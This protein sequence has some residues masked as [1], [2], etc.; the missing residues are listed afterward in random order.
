MEKLKFAYI[1]R[2]RVGKR[3]S[4]TQHK[5]HISEW[6]HAPRMGQL[7]RERTQKKICML[8]Y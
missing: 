5:Y 1:T 8:S 6:E 2:G 7:N 3:R 4:A